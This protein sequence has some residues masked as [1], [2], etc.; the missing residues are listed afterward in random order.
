MNTDVIL[1]SDF[2][3]TAMNVKSRYRIGYLC[4]SVFICVLGVSLPVRA[5]VKAKDAWVRGTVPA[6][7]TT[8]AFVTLESTDD[9]KVIGVK[10]PAA[11]T[12][13]IH[14]S[15]MKDGVMHM[16]AVESLALPAGK[17]VEL[18]PGGYHVM[19]MGLAKALGEG[20]AV[21]LVFTIEDARGK[22]TTLEVKAPVRPLGR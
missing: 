3:E 6:Q 17:R 8:G 4:S 20:D 15:G 7:T 1:E 12:A 9:A 2:R 22:R 10:S 16:H 18:Q 21:P 19:L 11:K 14:S 13:E 5:E